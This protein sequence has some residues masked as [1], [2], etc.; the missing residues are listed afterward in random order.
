MY[1]E[2]FLLCRRVLCTSEA[3]AWICRFPGPLRPVRAN[4]RQSR[5]REHGPALRYPLPAGVHFQLQYPS[6]GSV[7]LPY[8]D[9]PIS[10]YPQLFLSRELP[11]AYSTL[12]TPDTAP[13]I[14]RSQYR[15]LCSKIMSCFLPFF[16]LT[17]SCPPDDA[18]QYSRTSHTITAS[19]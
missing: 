9:A 12:R 18:W 17:G 15:T 2:L 8:P 4:R 14:C 5:L 13:A 3:K 11:P 6:S 7:P 19:I 10:S 16:P 1:K